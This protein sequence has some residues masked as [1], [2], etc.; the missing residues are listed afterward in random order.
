M[1]RLA[2]V[3]IS[4]KEVTDTLIT[5]AVKKFSDPFDQLLADL[6]AKRKSLGGEKSTAPAPARPARAT[7]AASK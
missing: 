5:E 6:D 7:A 1:N 2:E 4:M 3:G